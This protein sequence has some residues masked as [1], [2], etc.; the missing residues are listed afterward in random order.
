MLQTPP[1]VT[2]Q[3]R[4]KVLGGQGRGDSVGRKERQQLF[5]AQVSQGFLGHDLALMQD[6]ARQNHKINRALA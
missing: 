2:R 1:P 4:Q 3:Q 6:P 5:G